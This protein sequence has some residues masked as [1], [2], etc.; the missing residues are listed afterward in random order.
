MPG[1]GTISEFWASFG[2]GYLF[3]AATSAIMLFSVNIKGGAAAMI[4]L[5]TL[6]FAFWFV[7]L[8]ALIIFLAAGV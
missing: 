7:F 2:F 4:D 3:S 8:A 6:L 1:Q 5:A